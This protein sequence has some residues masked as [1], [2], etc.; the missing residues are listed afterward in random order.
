LRQIIGQISAVSV[1]HREANIFNYYIISDGLDII[2][3][4]QKSTN[5]DQKR[6]NNENSAF[7]AFLVNSAALFKVH[8]LIIFHVALCFLNFHAAKENRCSFMPKFSFNAFIKIVSKLYRQTSTFI[9]SPKKKLLAKF[10]LL[11]V[12]K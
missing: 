5:G 6:R 4:E 11:E 12:F 3:R 7:F 2:S 10:L 1:D 8:A 9:F